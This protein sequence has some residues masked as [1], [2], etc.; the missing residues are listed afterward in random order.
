MQRQGKANAR[1][2]AREINGVCALS[3]SQ[4]RLLGAA[5]ERLGLSGRALHRV[6]KVARTI[7]DL[8][9]TDRLGDAHLMEAIA[10]RQH[11]M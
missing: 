7:A 10:Y 4:R 11:R 2:G 1:L 6:L 8:E 5:M 9:G 3:G